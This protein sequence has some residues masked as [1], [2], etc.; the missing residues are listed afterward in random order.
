MN[1]RRDFSNTARRRAVERAKMFKKPTRNLRQQ[2]RTDESNDGDEREAN[3]AAEAIQ[4]ISVAKLSSVP[5]V[6][7]ATPLL[8]FDEGMLVA[9]KQS[10]S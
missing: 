6:V 4:A 2:R 3:E 10:S 5:E 7:K 9:L 8:S 1:Q